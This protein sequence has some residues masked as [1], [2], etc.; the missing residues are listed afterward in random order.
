MKSPFERVHLLGI[1]VD[2]ARLGEV[3]EVCDTAISKGGKLSIGVVNAAKVVNMRENEELRRAVLSSDL[4]LADGMAVVWASR[5]LG[6]PLPERIAGI[7]LFERLMDRANEKG[8]S[9]FL[10]GA[11]ASVLKKTAEVIAH[12]RPGLR[13]VG[14]RDGYFK[15]ADTADVVRS[16]REANPQLLFIAM[17]SP[18]KEV[19][20][21]RW[22]DELP[23]N[24]FHGV[25]GS[26]DVIAGATSRAP[27]LLRNAGLEWFYRL[28]QEPGRLW[29]RYLTTNTMFIV[30][31]LK[32]LLGRENR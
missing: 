2:C 23:A 17:S 3:L 14:M 19:F 29:K 31:V 12:T 1:D 4:V 26:F 24:V 22:K 18:K 6:R 21:E 25:G 32:A 28:I 20:L 27:V 9:V 11:T 16:I 5:L 10:L 13:I 7:D 30:M 8:W 15:E